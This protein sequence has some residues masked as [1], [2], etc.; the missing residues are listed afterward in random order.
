MRTALWWILKARDY[1]LSTV[2]TTISRTL[3][4]QCTVAVAR[5]VSLRATPVNFSVL[6]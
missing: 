5:K 4:I 2:M 3:I 6:K 1:Q